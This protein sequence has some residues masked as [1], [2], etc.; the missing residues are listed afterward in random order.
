[1][2]TLEF[3]GQTHGLPA[4]VNLSLTHTVS[5]ANYQTLTKCLTIISEPALTAKCSGVLCEESWTLE[6]T[7][8]DT[9]M[10]NN[11]VSTSTFCIAR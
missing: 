2:Q 7:L 10:R 3:E 6:L 4:L 1:M 11:T 9:P 8:A 5:K